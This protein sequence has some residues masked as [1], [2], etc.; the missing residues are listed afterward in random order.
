[1]GGELEL[2]SEPGRGTTFTILLDP[3]EEL[4]EAQPA[5]EN[6]KGPIEPEKSM[7]KEFMRQMG[8]PG[9]TPR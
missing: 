2:V 7:V 6:R 4:E 5:A 1:M 8:V 3:T 9:G